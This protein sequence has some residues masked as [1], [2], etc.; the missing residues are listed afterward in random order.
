[1][2]KKSI[3]SNVKTTKKNNKINKKA[4]QQKDNKID[5]KEIQQK[6]QLINKKLADLSVI[7]IQQNKEI[8]KL[9]KSMMQSLNMC[10]ENMNKYKSQR[11]LLARTEMTRR[12]IYSSINMLEKNKL[13]LYMIDENSLND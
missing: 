4:S 11:E 7:V 3:K 8:E 1:M 9:L 12:V 10:N 2:S 5:K 13:R 6:K